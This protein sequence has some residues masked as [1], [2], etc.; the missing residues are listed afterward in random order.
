MVIPCSS[1]NRE[2]VFMV[3]LCIDLDCHEQ[4]QQWN[5]GFRSYDISSGQQEYWRMR[6]V[7]K[8]QTSLH[9]RS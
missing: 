8:R 3:L 2:R 9:K 6:T 5:Y 7:W 1:E 4:M